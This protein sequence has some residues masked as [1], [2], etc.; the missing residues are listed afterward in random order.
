[1]KKGIPFIVFFPGLIFLVILGFFGHIFSERWVENNLREELTRLSDVVHYA[2][3]SKKVMALEGTRD[4]EKKPQYLDLQTQFIR[5]G[6]VLKKFDIAWIYILRKEEESWI[7]LVDSVEV[8]SPDHAFPGEV[9]M[10]HPKELDLML[11]TQEPTIVGPY[12]DQ[13][14]TF[15][16]S[17]IPMRNAS[18]G[19]VSDILGLDIYADVWQRE[20][21]Q[22]QI[23]SWTGVGVLIFF[24]VIFFVFQWKRS[25]NEQKIHIR[26]LQ[27]ESV[28]NNI[29]DVVYRVNQ[30]GV[31]T[32]ISPSCERIFG[33]TP[34]EIE[35]K[36]ID[37][38]FHSEVKNEEKK[39]F[40]QAFQVKNDRPLNISLLHKNGTK[41]DTQILGMFLEEK[42]DEIEFQGI[43]HD[44]GKEQ[45]NEEKIKDQTEYLQKSQK[46]LL[47][48]LKDIEMEREKIE[49]EKDKLNAIVY[50]IGDGV[51]V[52]DKDSRIILANN[53][54]SQLSGY[55]R[56]ELL[57]VR[58]YETMK[59]VLENDTTK[60]DMFVEDVIRTGVMKQR[61]ESVVLI[62]KNGNTIP[63]A[64]SASPF[65]NKNGEIIGCVVVFRDVTKDREINKMKSE[66]VSVASH[67]LR[68]PLTS[69]K[70][71][72]ELLFDENNSN[73]T[74]DQKEWIKEIYDGNE[75]LIDLVNDL[76]NVSRIETG[77]NF[78]VERKKMDVVKIIRD[79]VK[80]QTPSAKEKNI[81]LL[82]GT[83]IP[84]TLL[85]DI[86]G[87]KIEQVFQNLL[88]NAI[89]YSPENSEVQ[90]G[91]LDEGSSVCFSVKDSGIG[92][93]EDQKKHLFEKF[94][95][96][97][98]VIMTETQGTGL[99]LYIAKSIIEGH[100]GSIWFESHTKGTTFFIRLHK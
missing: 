63:V 16:S 80:K 39:K 9:Y 84:E 68:T 50:S 99:G 69:I 11:Q 89:K 66:F 23:M 48:V 91:F 33:Y 28:T 4:D 61:S 29:Q 77:K 87:V 65:K 47:N 100:G 97:S 45:K 44:V 13:W 51:F 37:T 55:S 27:L 95:R 8:S 71:F 18:T 57:D 73:L 6:E 98:N 14:G 38:F 35:G 60:I 78:V 93:P 81:T 22:A 59:F 90:F 70:W 43:I 17:F 15:I 67:Q 12:S 24:W 56:E 30:D 75:R 88:S 54:A 10:S 42:P 36:S 32:Y 96:A 53:I 94:F 3:E 5:I 25:Q 41:I 34:S 49:Q 64:H 82:L 19:E 7:F 62:Q 1:M 86:D 72:A 40:F 46:A 26:E 83:H 74:S 20:I 76:L 85:L 79:V 52:V 21:V 58:Y 31:I 2:I 92:I